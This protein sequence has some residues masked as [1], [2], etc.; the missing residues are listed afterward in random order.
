MALDMFLET[1]VWLLKGE[2]VHFLYLWFMQFPN[3]PWHPAKGYKSLSKIY[4]PSTCL[5][6]K[7]LYCRLVGLKEPDS[8]F[9]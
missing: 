2:L 4:D 3:K 7:T 5:K 9:L 8:N 6:K 1:F